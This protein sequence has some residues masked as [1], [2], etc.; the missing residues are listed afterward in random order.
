MSFFLFLGCVIDADW[1][2]DTDSHKR[3]F[4]STMNYLDIDD[5]TLVIQQCG[6]ANLL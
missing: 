4:S 6:Q 3:Q 2:D 1:Y 5:M